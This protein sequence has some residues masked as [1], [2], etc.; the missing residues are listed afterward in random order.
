MIQW[1]D[2]LRDRFGFRAESMEGDPYGGLGAFVDFL[3][4]AG[5]AAGITMGPDRA[6]QVSSVASCVT[7]LSEGVATLPLILYRRLEG[8]G[9]ERATDHPLYPVMRV[10]PSP[11]HT[12]VEL[13]SLMQ[14]DLELYG[15][16]Y[17]LRVRLRGELR[18]LHWLPARRV[19]PKRVRGRVTYKLYSEDGTEAVRELAA[20]RVL[21]L[22]GPGGDGLCGRATTVQFRELFALAY[23]IEAF[24]AYSFKNGVT[25]SGALKSANKLSDAYREQLKKWI[26]EEYQGHS[27]VGRLMLLEQGLDFQEMTQNH[28]DAQVVELWE[29]SVAAVARVFGVPLHMLAAHIAQPRA[30][31]EQQAREFVDNALKRRLV[32]WEQRLAA[33]LL[34]PAEQPEYFFEFLLD[35]LLRGD[36][37]ARSKVYRVLIELGVMTRNEVRIRE[38]LNPLDGLDEP[39]TPLNMN[40]GGA[41]NDEAV[42][43]M[44]ATM[45]AEKA[46]L[47]LSTD[48]RFDLVA[49]DTRLAL[50]VFR[51]LG[52]S[53]TRLLR[54]QKQ[55]RTI[56]A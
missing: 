1:L 30:N 40:R 14:E 52:V 20:D 12:S 11:D 36:A 55:G 56:P 13:R 6:M 35:D 7:I 33:D 25:L 9:K 26:K 43:G 8:G 41:D 32:R 48:E 45:A 29:K 39:L 46:S 53:E 19:E 31:M 38:N 51:R 17:A 2:G 16:A 4:E 27:K 49:G 21:H 5:T 3:R 22:R 50:A 23:V 47:E 10:K 37:E 24:L 34:T 15:S 28:H 44:A 18:E 42:L 54:L